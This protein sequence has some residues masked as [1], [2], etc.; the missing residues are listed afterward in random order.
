MNLK[1]FNREIKEICKNY[2]AIETAPNEYKVSTF[3]GDLYIYAS[4]S[5]QIKVYTV[6]MRFLEPEKFSLTTFFKYFS[7]YEIFNK[8]SLK[9]NL[10]HSDAE[11]IICETLERLEN[12]DFINNR[13]FN[14]PLKAIKTYKEI[15]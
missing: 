6:Y 14:Q 1:T 12:L 8:W 2:N 11:L 5:P 13:D 4:A 9:W 15:A 10:H 3:L 7:K